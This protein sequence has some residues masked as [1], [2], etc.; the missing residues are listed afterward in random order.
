MSMAS[1]ELKVGDW[2]MTDYNSRPSQ[3]D[4]LVKV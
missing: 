4:S 3:Q 2:E 1:R